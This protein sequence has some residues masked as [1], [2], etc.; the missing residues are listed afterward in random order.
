MEMM[1][2]VARM[3]GEGE[4][5]VGS[6]SRGRILS[7]VVVVLGKGWISG[8]LDGEMARGRARVCCRRRKVRLMR[9]TR[10]E[11]VD[12]MMRMTLCGRSSHRWLT[13]DS[14]TFV[15]GYVGRFLLGCMCGTLSGALAAPQTVVE[16]AYTISLTNDGW[17]LKPI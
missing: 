14:G 13:N 17:F 5:S 7:V 4:L 11:M 1:M 12:G 6:G 8:G 15:R 2:M 3:A 9:L 16:K 10:A